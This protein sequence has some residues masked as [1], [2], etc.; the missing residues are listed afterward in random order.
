MIISLL[1]LQH[2]FHD[3]PKKRSKFFMVILALCLMH[4]FAIEHTLHENL[5]RTGKFRR[6]I[7]S[8][9]KISLLA[10]MKSELISSGYY[11][12]NCKCLPQG[13]FV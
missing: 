10:E 8:I 11:D 7:V 1:L 6:K 4:V 5:V 3:F 9:E 12:S 2:N 13:L